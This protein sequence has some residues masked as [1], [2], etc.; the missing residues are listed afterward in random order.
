[1][2]FSNEPELLEN[3]TSRDPGFIQVSLSFIHHHP[4][5]FRMAAATA[6]GIATEVAKKS[7]Q[8]LGGI[9]YGRFPR[10]KVLL[11]CNHCFS[12]SLLCLAC[13]G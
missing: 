1:M 11:R 5:L 8:K 12:E 7:Q 3:G 9:A 13:K 10:L 2:A 4:L 6:S